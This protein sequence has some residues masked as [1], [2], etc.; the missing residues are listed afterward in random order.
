MK[1]NRFLDGLRV[2]TAITGNDLLMALKNKNALMAFVLAV[3]MVFFYHFM[4]SLSS[5]FVPQRLFVYNAEESALAVRLE[6]SENL[7]VRTYPTEEQMK[8]ALANSDVPELGLVIPVGFD[9]AIADGK[10][11]RL[12]GYRMNWLSQDEVIEQKLLVEAEISR[13]IERPVEVQLEGNVVYPRLTSHGLSDTVG[14]SLLYVVLM[15]VLPMIP[16]LFLEE[17][18]SRTMEALMVSPASAG[19]IVIGKGLSG[20][21]YCLLGAAITLVVYWN[22]IVHW[23]LMVLAVLSGSIFAVAIGLWL[24]M[25]IESRGQLSLILSAVIVP[26][27]VPPFLTLMEELFPAWLVQIFRII[28]TTTLLDLIRISAAGSIP[29]GTVVGSLVW[30]NAWAAAILVLVVLQVLRLDRQ[31]GPAQRAGWLRAFQ[32]LWKTSPRAESHPKPIAYQPGKERASQNTPQ[33]NLASAQNVPPSA[34]KLVWTIA[35]KDM[36]SAIQNKI[37]LS[38]LLGTATLGSMNILFPRLI[39]RQNKPTF[40]VYDEG[41]STIIR[42]LLGREDFNLTVLETFQEMEDRVAN[43]LGLAVGLMLPPDFDQRAGSGEEIVLDRYVGHAQNLSK[44]RQWADYFAQQINQASG[45]KVRIQMDNHF[46]Y[47]SLNSFGQPVI[48]AIILPIIIFTLGVTLVP[49]LFVEEREGHTLEALL[50]SPVR[51]LQVVAGKALAGAA[52][53][54]LASAILVGVNN[55]LYVHWEAVLLA[56][57]LFTFFTVAVGLLLGILSDNPTTVTIWGGIILLFMIALSVL[58]MV[59]LPILPG[60]MQQ[61]LAWLP[62]SVTLNLLQLSMV[63]E[64]PVGMLWV[65]AGAL[66][67]AGLVVFCL[68]LWR[69]RRSDR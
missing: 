48:T 10:E 4:P 18:R 51:F 3:L 60:F 37:F 57:G 23:W 64:V 52:Y 59:Q 17:K 54:L 67:A 29:W 9:Q 38:I 36:R 21:F 16:H 35:F 22:A 26:L 25:R 43:G 44:A 63:R 33:L 69:L 8:T 1:R 66:L 15:S 32:Q 14:I 11:L 58:H 12:Q 62:A 46:L 5:G 53:C 42:G 13:L 50:V 61:I 7:S 19:Q 6:S 41:N 68:V 24:G 49:L 2:L 30:I 65:N 40:V 20:L 39:I 27:L 28:P 31:D 56:V 34:W 45:S 47:P 55:R